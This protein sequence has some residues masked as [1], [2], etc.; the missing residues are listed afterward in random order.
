M[1]QHVV[2]LYIIISEKYEPLY[3]DYII[4]LLPSLYHSVECTQKQVQEVLGYLDLKLPAQYAAILMV[5][6]K[7]LI[8]MVKIANLS[9]SLK[10]IPVKDHHKIVIATFLFFFISI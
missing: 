8:L 4:L 5:L 7:K 6:Y 2:T 10:Y 1:E 9:T 3:I